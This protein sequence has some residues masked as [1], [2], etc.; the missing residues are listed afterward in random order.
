MGLAQVTAVTRGKKM[1]PLRMTV[2]G[3][4]L[5][6]G[7]A[8]VQSGMDP[9]DPNDPNHPGDPVTYELKRPT[10]TN[11]A[12]TAV[13]L[14]DIVSVFGKDFIDP[15][16]GTLSMHLVGSFR[17][18]D[19]Q[20]TTRWEGD[21]PL[22]YVS[23]GKATF[24]FGPG[25][26]FSPSGMD[27]GAF[28][29][30]FQAVNTLTHLA[31]NAEVGDTEI[32]EVAQVTMNAM[33]SL[34]VEQIRS[35]DQNC[36]LITTGT[37]AGSNMAIGMRAL[38]MPKGTVA[39][40]IKFSVTFK[41][42]NMNVA[43]VNNQPYTAWPPSIS[44]S[45]MIP[46]Q[47]GDY[48]IS[49]E[50]SNDNAMTLD[51]LHYETVVNVNPPVVVNQGSTNTVKLARFAAGTLDDKTNSSTLNLILQATTADGTQVLSRTFNFKNYQPLELQAWNGKEVD[52]QVYDPE[53]TDIGCVSGGLTG[54]QYSYSEG[55]SESRSRSI[56]MN[57]N[58]MAQVGL[59]A[60]VW[61]LRASASSTTTFGVDVNQS[62]STET[63]KNFTSTIN[64]L[65]QYVGVSYRQAVR[66][67][68]YAPAVIHTTCGVSQDVGTATLTNWRWNF[69][70]NQGPECPP[71]PSAQMPPAEMF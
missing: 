63:H 1:R 65:P 47:D 15:D 36:D 32:S 43:F 2:L 34:Y 41:A 64:V 40:P 57:W 21:V 31:I 9:M 52:K 18:D 14:G 28:T 42:P 44:P 56:S 58:N 55:S 48:T 24:E 62:V 27:L 54:Q 39:N 17:K 67:E 50:V 51:P 53:M 8:P 5:A 29:G 19:D 30:N 16:H 66:S 37:T 49:Y 70:I 12:P 22:T 23:P 59:D 26:F 35:V 68:R 61:I 20:S 25:V 33:P 3:L 46:A 45:A 38:G 10:L 4:L 60:N 11:V 6:A 69:D 71:P 7:C 13:A